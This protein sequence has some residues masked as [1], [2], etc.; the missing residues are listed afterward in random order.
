SGFPL[1]ASARSRRPRPRRRYGVLRRAVA[2]NRLPA[3][4]PCRDSTWPSGESRLAWFQQPLPDA[5]QVR[6]RTSLGRE[7]NLVASRRSPRPLAGDAPPETLRRRY[8][9]EAR[10]TTPGPT[11]ARSYEFTQRLEQEYPHSA[12]ARPQ[13]PGRDDD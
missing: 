5:A 11:G 1:S 7:R 13:Q 2:I 10:A 8:G 3:E 4:T 6:V 12:W 9:L